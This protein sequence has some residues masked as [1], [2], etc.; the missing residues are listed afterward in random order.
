V[1]ATAVLAINLM[2]DG[3]RDMLDPRFARRL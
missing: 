1:L 3:L 2:G